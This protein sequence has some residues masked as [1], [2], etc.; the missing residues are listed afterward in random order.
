MIRVELEPP[1]QLKPAAVSFSGLLGGSPRLA[2][3]RP[4][5]Q[6]ALARCGALELQSAS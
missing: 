2:F 5:R 4:E 1:A 6:D 3:S